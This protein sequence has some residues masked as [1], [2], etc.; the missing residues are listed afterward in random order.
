MPLEQK[1]KS[2]HIFHQSV[3]KVIVL[4]S[5]VPVVTAIETEF[6]LIRKKI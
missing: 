6:E 5:W 1:N 2:Q 4:S 3:F